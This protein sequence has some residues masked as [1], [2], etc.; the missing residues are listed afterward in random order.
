MEIKEGTR[1][2]CKEEGF[3]DEEFGFDFL[4][5]AYPNSQIRRIKGEDDWKYHVDFLVQRQIDQI[6]IDFKGQNKHTNDQVWMEKI[7]VKGNCGW[8]MGEANFILFRMKDFMLSGRRVD[9]L[10]YVL[11]NV[12]E[13]QRVETKED[14]YYKWYTRSKWNRLDLITLVSV[15]SLIK[16][17]NFKRFTFDAELIK[18]KEENTDF[19]F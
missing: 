10:N 3:K 5:K 1:E 2:R 18:E 4:K 19:G 6:K 11:Q 15:D 14:A 16:N 13:D 12:P 7:N 9:G 17:A 8:L